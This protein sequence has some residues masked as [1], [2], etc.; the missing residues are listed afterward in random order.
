MKNREMNYKKIFEDATFDESKVDEVS[1]KINIKPE[2]SLN[3]VYDWLKI[4]KENQINVKAVIVGTF[5]PLAGRERGMYYSTK[6]NNVYKYLDRYLND[7]NRLQ[8]LKE[9]FETNKRSNKDIATDIATYVIKNKLI[10]I[11]V[12]KKRADGLESSPSDEDIYYFCCDKDSFIPYINRGIKFLCTSR[13]T[14]YLLNKIFIELN[15]HNEEIIYVPQIV[16]SL[17]FKG[18]DD[19]LPLIE[20]WNRKLIEVLG[21]RKNND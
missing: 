1:L 14:E 6:E 3:G 13:E 19:R 11:D 4:P 10:F 9:E 20:Y 21:V 8:S 12:M 15:A 5:T 2:Y 17:K 18:N 16:R 7:G